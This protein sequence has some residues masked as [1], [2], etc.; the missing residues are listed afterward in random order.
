MEIIQKM[1]GYTPKG[2]A[3]IL[4]TLTNNQGSYVK[5]SNI[6]ANIVGIGVP[7]KNGVI[8]DVL[9]GYDD[10]W[11]YFNDPPYFG[12]T[13][14]QYANRICKGRFTLNGKDYQLAINNGPNHLHGG[15]QSMCVQ[16]WVSRVEEDQQSV[17]FSYFS[18]DGEENYPGNV[19]ITVT[20]HW[21]EQNVL[22]IEY[23]ATTD[24]T[25]IINLTNHSYFN[26]AGEG[27][28]PIYDHELQIFADNYLPV[29]ETCIPLG[30]PQPV[31][32]TPF[33]F[34]SPKTIGRDINADNLQLK[35]GHGYDHCWCLNKSDAPLATA[36]I[37]KDPTSGRTLT[38]L[39]DQPGLQV[40]TG[41]WLEGNGNDKNGNLHR[42]QYAVALEC[43]NYP[44]APNHQDDYP[45]CLLQPGQGYFRTIRFAFS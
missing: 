9:A 11:R 45:S 7:D 2:D 15:P 10:L 29:D 6:G 36:A 25:T 30:G 26:L 38:V 33:D 16:T 37:L 8:K 19:Q 21:D 20:Y 3:I 17:S 34:R 14:G 5:L 1:A 35:I 18:P 24:K 28:G 12:K 4:Y 43:Q 31:A 13:V 27:S 23:R 40:Y 41:N 32:D 22:T 44:D 42:N 39:T